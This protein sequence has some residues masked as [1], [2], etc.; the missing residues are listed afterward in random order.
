MNVCALARCCWRSR[1]S[2][3]RRSTTLIF[4]VSALAIRR[5]RL[6]ER[7]APA[8]HTGAASAAPERDVRERG[9]PS[10]HRVFRA[11]R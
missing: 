3:P 10:S 5:Y 9:Q 2:T 1:S 11:G 6:M 7:R 4:L 8:H